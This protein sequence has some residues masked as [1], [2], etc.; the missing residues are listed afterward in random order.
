M[1]MASSQ[2][3]SVGHYAHKNGSRNLGDAQTLMRVLC[4]MKDAE[5]SKFLKRHYN[6][7][8]S[9]GT[10]KFPPHLSLAKQ[11]VSKIWL[12]CLLN[13]QTKRYVD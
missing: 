9:S 4:H 13:C 10:I 2:H 7:P 6:L 8:A 11:D 12:L 1:L 5:A 3:I